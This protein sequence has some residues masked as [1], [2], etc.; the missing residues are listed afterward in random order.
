AYVITFGTSWMIQANIWQRISAARK[1]IDAKKMMLFSFIAFIPLYF[2]VVY[3][4]MFSSVT[5]DTV[6]QSGIVPTMISGLSNP[7]LSSLL[8]VGLCAAIMSTMDSLINTGALSLT[9]DIYEKYINPKASS[10][11]NV[12]VGRISTLLIGA[13]ALII[14]L[15]I[16]SVLTIAW[17]GS[18]FLTS[19]AFIPLVLG[20]LWVRGT[21]KAAIASMLFGLLFSTYNLF[22][23]LGVN[24]PVA[25]DTAS[26]KQAIIGISGSL[27]L[28]IV[29]SLFT[30]DDIEKSRRFIKKAD[31]LNKHS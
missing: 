12:V 27:F 4:G 5:Y 3:T 29:I 23:A 1:A 20:F 31:I 2:M 14:A 9:V 8:F 6:P 21:S 19:G 25:W 16:R 28:F 10:A 7:Y 30:S 26:A 18:D 24:L 17:I 11:Q 15:Q 22:V 13:I